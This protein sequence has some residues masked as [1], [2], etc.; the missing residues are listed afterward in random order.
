M[1][2]P[3]EE[4]Y[5]NNSSSFNSLLMCNYRKKASTCGIRLNVPKETSQREKPETSRWLVYCKSFH[6]GRVHIHIK[7]QRNRKQ[8][9]DNS[10]APNVM[11]RSQFQ[12]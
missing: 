5:K 1:Y 8:F 7:N 3:L 11:P 6:A 9:E 2:Q 12:T 10:F 4:R